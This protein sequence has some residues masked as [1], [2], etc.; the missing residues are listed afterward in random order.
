LKETN[1]SAKLS[2]RAA[3]PTDSSTADG[4]AIA[5]SK[6]G[7]SAGLAGAFISSVQSTAQSVP[8]KLQSVLATTAQNPPKIDSKFDREWYVDSVVERSAA[9]GPF[10]IYFFLSLSGDLTTDPKNYSQSPYLAGINHIFA[11]PREVC[12]N[13]GDLEAA[14]QLASDTSPITPLLLD[15]VDVPD[16]DLESLRPEHVKPFLVKYLRWRVVY[17]GNL[18]QDPRDVPDLKVSVSAKV[19]HQDGSKTF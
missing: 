6:T 5:D 15:Y 14:G 13:C 2:R 19:Y 18:K 10:T 3:N 17:H 8:M 11:A 4:G 7:E 16:N 9:N 1:G 12:S